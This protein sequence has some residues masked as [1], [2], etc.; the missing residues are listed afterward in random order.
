MKRILITGANGFIGQNL[1][2][3]MSQLKSFEIVKFT[4]DNDLSDLKSIV[5]NVDFVYH[6]AGEVKPKSK[7]RE[8]ETSNVDLTKHLTS[9]LSLFER[10]VPIVLASTIHA[11]ISETD[12]AVTKKK[13]ENII[14]EYSKLQKVRCFIFKLPHIFGE[15]CKPNHNTVI[16]TWIYN[17]INDININVFDRNKKMEYV[18]IRDVVSAFLH[19][20]DSQVMVIVYLC[21]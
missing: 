6:L 8:F 15:N 14:E 18:Y 13:S 1:V 21:T 17:S 11:D 19:C 16:T 20:L 12:Y 7:L 5:K 9:Q 3:R 4:R 2:N 10:K